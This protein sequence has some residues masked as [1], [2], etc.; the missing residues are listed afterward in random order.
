MYTAKDVTKFLNITKETLRHYERMDLIHPYIDP[1]NNYRCYSDWDIFS[2]AEC[3]LY[4]SLDFAIKE[5]NDL[6]NVV[7]LEQYQAF[8][9]HKQTDYETKAKLFT[10]LALRNEYHHQ[11][12][13]EYLKYHGSFHIGTLDTRYIHFAYTDYDNFQRNGKY[14]NFSEMQLSDYAFADFSL[15]LSWDNIP[16]MPYKYVGGTSYTSQW[17]PYISILHKNLL[18]LTYEKAIILYAETDSKIALDQSIFKDLLTYMGE[19]HYHSSS[20]I[21]AT[22]I[23]QIKDIRYFKIWVPI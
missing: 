6:Q 1:R 10:G 21:F 18:P 7:S 12:L 22:Q 2:I 14:L 3:R 8:L 23:A 15:L 9:E 19:K 4:R 5:I 16:D 13:A 17:V 11:M 20:D